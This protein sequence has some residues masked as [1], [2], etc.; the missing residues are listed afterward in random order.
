MADIIF[1]KYL[2][3][4]GKNQ[5]KQEDCAKVADFSKNLKDHL[6]QYDKMPH[7]LYVND[8]KSNSCIWIYI[9]S[10]NSLPYDDNV[11]DVETNEKTMNPRQ[12]TQVE[13]RQQIFA[14]Y[15]Y[16]KQ[17]FYISNT[18]SISILTS[19]FNQA[20]N[21]HDITIK[22]I[23]KDFNDVL[24][25]FKSIKSIRLIAR[26]NLFT[27]TDNL[28]KTITDSFGLGV[29]G[30]YRIDVNFEYAT[31][32]DSAIGKLK[33][34]NSKRLGADLDGFICVGRDD[35]GLESVFNM[36]T[37]ISQISVKAAH[38]EKGMYSDIEVKSELIKQLGNINA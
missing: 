21:T 37:F 2:L 25:S 3:Y 19:F 35:G 29:P 10:G 1:H 20:L 14:L 13:L 4:I 23:L 30:Q 36:D 38:N 31:L 28:F 5:L 6:F 33:E 15:D 27:Q 9:K 11:I 34:L 32:T 7:E 17:S 8:D 16:K 18:K 26:N 24:K 12:I 22:K